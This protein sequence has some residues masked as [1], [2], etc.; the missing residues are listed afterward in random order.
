M[1]LEALLGRVP[2]DQLALVGIGGPWGARARVPFPAGHLPTRRLESVAAASLV[3]SVSPVLARALVRRFP[4]VR[5]VVAT[6]DPMIGLASQWAR[7]AGADLWVYGIDLHA[8]HFWGADAFLA[9]QMVAARGRALAQASRVFGLSHRM[10]EWLTAHGAR[11]QAEELPPLVD[12][13]DALPFPNGTPR[14]LYSGSVYGANA[15]PLCW[16]Q[17]AAADVG[18]PVELR[19][20]TGTT[21]VDLV[22]AGLDLQRWSVGKAAPDQVPAEVAQATWCVVALDPYARDRETL[23]VAW[24][25]KL[26]EYLAVGRPVFCISAPDYA[27]AELANQAG[28]GITAGSEEETRA[29]LRAALAETPQALAARA[30]RAHVFAKSRFD[31]QVIGEGWRREALA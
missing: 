29:A 12:V 1:M 26:R 22:R 31:N 25:T 11:A 20:L 21:Q 2:E 4:K 19:L 28:W 7:H 23:R 18:V 16:L 27:A 6:L 5:R 14:F 3:V 15:K 8:N 13:G 10:C 9:A 17:R 24:P 30:E